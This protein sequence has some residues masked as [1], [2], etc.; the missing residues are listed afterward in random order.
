MTCTASVHRTMQRSSDS[1]RDPSATRPRFGGASATGSGLRASP[2][3]CAFRHCP[4]KS[5]KK[6]GQFICYKSGQVYLLLTAACAGGGV[7][8]RELDTRIGFGHWWQRFLWSHR[9]QILWCWPGGS[10]NS[11]PGIRHL[12][13]CFALRQRGSLCGLPLPIVVFSGS[14]ELVA[15]RLRDLQG[16]GVFHDGLPQPFFRAALWCGLDRV[17]AEPVLRFLPRWRPARRCC[18]AWRTSV[19]RGAPK[20]QRGCRWCAA[21]GARCR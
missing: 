5:Q 15:K 17:G 12:R 3:P 18:R 4:A 9:R 11:I 14:L 1:L 16:A 2:S 10:A 7:L 8:W 19:H 6:S 13:C 20:C 21:C